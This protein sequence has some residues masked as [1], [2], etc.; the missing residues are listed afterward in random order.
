VKRVIEALGSWRLI[1]VMIFLLVAGSSAGAAT[2][3]HRLAIQV[4][5]NDPG[6]MN[7]ALNNAAN[8]S[9][10]YSGLGQDVEVEIVAF[11]PGLN[12]L[13]ADMSPV[14]A[15]LKQFAE[16]MPNVKFD[17]CNNTLQAMEKQEGK[18]IDIVPEAHLV[19]SGV[20]RIMTLEEQGWSYIRP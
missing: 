6:K 10:Y 13:R 17:A 8:V 18:K 9:S 5:E 1:V 19:P 2:N 7:L 16:G 14:K 15:R 12:M 11:G 4:S 3:V 20:V